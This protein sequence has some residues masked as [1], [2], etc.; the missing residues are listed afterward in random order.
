G[1]MD[2]T[3]WDPS[4]TLKPRLN[5]SLWGMKLD[6]EQKG[7]Y[8]TTRLN[9]ADPLKVILGG[10][11]DWYKADADTDSYKVTR[12]VTRYAGVIYDLNQ[13]YSVYASYT[14][15]FKPQSNFDAGGGLLDPITGKNYEIGLKGE[16]FG[17]ALNS[18][19]ALFQIDQENRATEDVGGPS[20]CPFSP[21][22]RYCSRASGKV[23]SQ[24]V[25][26]ELS[27]ALSDDWQMMAGY[28]YVDAKY[29]HDSNKA[30]E[31]KPFDAAKPRHLFKLATS[32]TLPGELHK[33]RVG[34]DLATQSKTE[35]SST[36]FQQGGYTVVNA[37]LGYKVSER[38][39]TRLN[40][41]NLFDKYYYSGID[42]GN[43][44][45]GEPRN[46]MFTVKYSL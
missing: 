34:G 29:K 40:F 6:Q 15:I 32:Y 14:D 26:L 17:G 1:P 8:L 16:H 39:D 9:L 36:G 12:N 45:Y 4:S 23:R 5:T 28:T 10:R 18:Q 44:N 2:P 30:N 33:W 24:G 43:L 35:D 7:A 38:I 41:N 21:T 20:P 31:G 13:T 11:L 25:D 46:L 22:S 3:Q 42:F 37:M 27:G 19:I